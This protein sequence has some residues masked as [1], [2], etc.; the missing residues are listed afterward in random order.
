MPPVKSMLACSQK[1][2]AS[3]RK[4]CKKCGGHTLPTLRFGPG[5][6]I[7]YAESVLPMRDGLAEFRDF[8]AKFG[9]SGAHIA[10]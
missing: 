10:E 6:H 3:Q 4:Y 9:G 2:A 5:V 1:T 8:R 7:N